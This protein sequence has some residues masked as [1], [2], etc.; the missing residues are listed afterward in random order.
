MGQRISA[1]VLLAAQF[2]LHLDSFSE[3]T[4]LSSHNQYSEFMA[5]KY[6]KKA[7]CRLFCK[8]IL[9]EGISKA[10]TLKKNKPVHIYMNHIA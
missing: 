2:L 8:V 7:L 5:S 1:P 4:S 6:L 10:L 9:S 3:T